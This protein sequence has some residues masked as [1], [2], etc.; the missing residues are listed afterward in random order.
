M[1]SK[2]SAFLSVA[3]ASSFAQEA[4]GAMGTPWFDRTIEFRPTTAV[5]MQH[6]LR[7]ADA[8]WRDSYSYRFGLCYHTLA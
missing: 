3:D 1:D 4:T 8:S 5:S 6:Q 2:L 7:A